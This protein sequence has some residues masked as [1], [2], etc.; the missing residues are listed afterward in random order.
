MR[1]SSLEPQRSTQ[2]VQLSH[3][4]VLTISCLIQMVCMATSLAEMPRGAW[5]SSRLR[6]ASQVW[7]VNE[8]KPAKASASRDFRD[9]HTH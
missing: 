8:A 6:K 1:S 4:M 7:S 5:Q 9:A 3:M 2:D